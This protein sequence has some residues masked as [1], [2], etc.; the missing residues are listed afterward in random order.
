[1]ME[2]DF[3]TSWIERGSLLRSASLL[4]QKRQ[5]QMEFRCIF[6]L[7]SIRFNYSE[8][9]QTY[10]SFFMYFMINNLTLPLD[11]VLPS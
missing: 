10:P 5:S 3:L 8:L 6:V 1:M 11:I 7:N 2:M 4:F 9:L